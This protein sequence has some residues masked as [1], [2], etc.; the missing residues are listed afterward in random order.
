M[1]KTLS[2][3]INGILII[4]VA[5][6]YYLHFSTDNHKA[7]V[8]GAEQKQDTIVSTKL[9]LPQ[10]LQSVSI[11]YVNADSLFEKYEYVKALKKEAMAKQ[12]NIE[13]RYTQ[14]SQRFQEDYMEY[15]QKASSGNISQDDAR[16]T[17]EELVKRKTELDDMEQ[18]LN[19]LMEETQRKNALV[20]TEV[21]NFF[22][23]YAKGRSLSYV[24]AYTSNAGS[25]LYANDSLDATSQLLD[26]LNARYMER[27]NKK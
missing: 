11:L 2:L 24:L 23:E 17:E 15:Q 7:G 21:T 10:Q 13:S 9:E 3:V 27:M 26:A 16:A 22:K 25:V 19:K 1:N 20:Q 6:L 14:K 18:Q 8:S 12:A 5:F 4:S